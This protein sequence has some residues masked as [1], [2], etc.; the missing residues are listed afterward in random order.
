MEVQLNPILPTDTYAKSSQAINEVRSGLRSV[1]SAME[2]IGI[3]HPDQEMDNILLDKF[4]A[5]P[6]VQKMLIEAAGKRMGLREIQRRR[7][8]LNQLMEL[9][10]TLPPAL[11]QAI[12]G[13]LMGGGA[14]PGGMPMPPEGG[15]QGQMGLPP[16]VMAAL[17]QQG[18]GAA[19]PPGMAAPGIQAAPGVQAAPGP[20]NP[21][22]AMLAQIAHAGPV[23][24]PSGIATGREPG[25]RQRGMEG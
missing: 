8:P 15:P 22:P 23:V 1:A 21:G 4:K 10:P 11:Q 17:A 19:G 12:Q 5:S 25:V 20:P 9:L 18:Q 13:T 6:E 14:Q 7:M 2:M 3:E 24:R 16:E